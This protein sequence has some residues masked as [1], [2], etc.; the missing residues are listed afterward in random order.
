[1]C[2][3]AKSL[4]EGWR[5]LRILMEFASGQALGVQGPPILRPIFLVHQNLAIQSI[6]NI[7]SSARSRKITTCDI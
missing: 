1:M 5:E 6:I 3:H 2:G 4:G 7:R